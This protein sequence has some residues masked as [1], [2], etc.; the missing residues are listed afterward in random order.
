MAIPETVVGEVK[1]LIHSATESGMAKAVH[2]A[3]RVLETVGFFY[4]GPL[5]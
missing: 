3:L 1:A 5:L 2:G 4:R